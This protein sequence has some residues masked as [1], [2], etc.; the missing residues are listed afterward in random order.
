MDDTQYYTGF[1]KEKLEKMDR[2]HK[3]Y[4]DK[5]FLHWKMLELSIKNEGK[6]QVQKWGVQEH[7]LQ[8]WLMFTTEELGELAKAI[9]EFVYRDGTTTE[10]YFEAIQVVTLALKIAEMIEIQR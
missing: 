6:N 8:E 5:Q 3:M 1:T 10:I 9:S 7:T 4:R 2:L